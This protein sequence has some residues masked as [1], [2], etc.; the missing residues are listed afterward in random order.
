MTPKLIGLVGRKR[1][2]KDT[3]AERL[4][5]AHGFTR[6]AFADALR[7]AALGL[8]PIVGWAFT[9]NEGV[10]LSEVVERHGWEGAKAFPEVRRTLQRYGVAIREIDPDFWLSVVFEPALR[11]KGPVVITDVRFP[12]EAQAVQSHGGKLV[13]IERTTHEPRD[14]HVSETALDDWKVD[15]VVVNGDT[16][17]SL[18]K[19]ADYAAGDHAF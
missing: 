6:Y 9:R 5:Q 2:G 12:N 10:R 1:V 18:H 8:D 13:R 19:C 16:I 3:F 14:L 17:R 7:K 4:V 11:E 15:L